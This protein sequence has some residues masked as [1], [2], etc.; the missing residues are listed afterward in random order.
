[1][2][3][4]S[5][6]GSA[7]NERRLSSILNHGSE[8]GP[9]KADWSSA[10]PRWIAAV[11]VAISRV[12]GLASFGLSRDQGAHSLTILLDGER[13]TLWFNA[14]ADLDVELQKVFEAFNTSI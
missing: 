8:T 6:R 4:K 2:A 1:M 12:G 10:D 11:V 14:S 7:N 9:G 13:Q 3:A 5:T